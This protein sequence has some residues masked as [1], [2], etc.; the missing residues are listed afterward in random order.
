MSGS[1]DGRVAL[2]TGGSAGIGRAA[3]VAFAKAGARV[4]VADTNADAAEGT[5]HL[6]RAFGGESLFVRTDVSQPTQVEAL[7]AAVVEKL[8]RLDA[9]F[10]N[11]G[12]EGKRARTADST[13]AEWDRVIGVNLTGVYLCMKHELRAMV[14]AGRGAIVNNASVAGQAGL[15][16]HPAYVASKHGI[17]GLTRAAALEYAK[18]GIRVNAVCPG[19]IRTEMIDRLTGGI[20]EAL[21]GL[22]A[23]EPVGR[24]GAPEEVAAAVVWLCSDEAS[25]V[26]GHAMA[27]D[28]GYLAQ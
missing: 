28:G 23:T 4:V 26:T 10:N 12:I 2:V 16:G 1:L 22:L 14:R 20:P 19:L 18:A 8:G 25:F 5:M 11:A 15:S 9:A 3:A 6:L 24:M 7:I 27:V 17:I 13:D 21:A